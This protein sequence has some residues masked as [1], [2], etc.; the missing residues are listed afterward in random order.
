MKPVGVQL[1]QAT[2]AAR[3]AD[4]DQLGRSALLVGGEHDPEGRTARRRRRR[5]E[6]AGPSSASPPWRKVTSNPSAARPG[7]GPRSA[8]SSDWDTSRCRSPHSRSGRRLGRRCR[9]RW[10]RPGR[11]RRPQVGGLDQLVGH[12]GR[13]RRSRR[14]PRSAAGGAY[15]GQVRSG[16]GGWARSSFQQGQAPRSGLIGWIRAWTWSRTGSIWLGGAELEEGDAF[17]GPAGMPGGPI[18]RP[19]R[20]GPPSSLPSGCTG[21]ASSPDRT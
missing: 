19:R 8:N 11:A 21:C 2:C 18:A 9:S 15:R 10:R 14:W 12:A 13:H 1:A 4:P 20:S 17:F 5:R 6:L 7:R 16:I 3:A